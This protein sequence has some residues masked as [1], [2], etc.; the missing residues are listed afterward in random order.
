MGNPVIQ[1]GHGQV[2]PECP[3][4]RRPAGVAQTP[5]L[6]ARQ[7][8][9]RLAICVQTPV[10]PRG[11]SPGPLPEPRQPQERLQREQR[12][13]GRLGLG[14]IVLGGRSAAEIRAQ[15]K[16]PAINIPQHQLRR[17]QGTCDFIKAPGY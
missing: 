16:A 5:D 3:P 14:G 11:R 13:G 9:D 17:N 1:I 8:D 10:I 7:V 15:A 6:A 2:R 12:L 4:C